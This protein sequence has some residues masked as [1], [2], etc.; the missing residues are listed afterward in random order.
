MTIEVA[1]QIIAGKTAQILV[2]EKT[3]GQIEIG[4]LL[5]GSFGDIKHFTVGCGGNSYR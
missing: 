4:D 2:R 1:G 5:S 3:G